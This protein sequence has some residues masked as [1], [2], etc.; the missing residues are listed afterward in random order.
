MSVSLQLLKVVLAS[1]PLEVGSTQGIHC[2]D[3][4]GHVEA[5]TTYE[6]QCSHLHTERCTVTCR[7]TNDELSGTK[8]NASAHT[9]FSQS[10]HKQC[11]PL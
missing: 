7:D 9:K 4:D 6:S 3:E 2:A 8:K 11:L 10:V 5:S 1:Q